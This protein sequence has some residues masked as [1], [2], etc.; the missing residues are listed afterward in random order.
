MFCMIA[1]DDRVP[2]HRI[3]SICIYYSIAHLVDEFWH[4]EVLSTPFCL[5]E[6]IC[7]LVVWFCCD[8]VSCHAFHL[9]EKYTIIS[10]LG[11]AVV[12]SLAT[13]F[14]L[15]KNIQSS[16]CLVLL[17]SCLLPYFSPCWKTYNHLVA[18]FCRGLVSYHGWYARRAQRALDTFVACFTV[19]SSFMNRPFVPL[20]LN[21][22]YQRTQIEPSNDQTV[23]HQNHQLCPKLPKVKVVSPLKSGYNREWIRR[24]AQWQGLG[25]KGNSVHIMP[26]NPSNTFIYI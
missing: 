24:G 16:R 26:T 1:W 5:V 12:L 14:T 23:F 15:L 20:A 17:W 4:F 7:N 10:L 9:V 11:S 22:S 21:P 18:W 8:L 13:L 25:W 6:K 19:L 2:E 3:G